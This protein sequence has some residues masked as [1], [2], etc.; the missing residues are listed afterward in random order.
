M[1][2]VYKAFGTRLEHEATSYCYYDLTFQI[3]PT[4]TTNNVISSPFK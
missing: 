1:A 2:V 4:E 3:T